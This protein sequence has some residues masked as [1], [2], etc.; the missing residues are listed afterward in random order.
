MLKSPIKHVKSPKR[1]PLRHSS[2]T[3]EFY[4]IYFKLIY[5]V[6]FSEN[7][8]FWSTLR[9]FLRTRFA[10][11]CRAFHSIAFPPAEARGGAEKDAYTHMLIST[12]FTFCTIFCRA[13]VQI[14]VQLFVCIVLGSVCCCGPR[15]S[16]RM[17]VDYSP[18]AY[19]T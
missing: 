6:V 15:L 17:C 12:I 11:N 10:M 19:R 18:S 7:A 2:I 5:T 16:Y 13:T 1:S 8:F 9:L 14:L 4:K 3:K